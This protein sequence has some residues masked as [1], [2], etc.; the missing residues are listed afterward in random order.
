MDE[1]EALP[2][3]QNARRRL[4]ARNEA[5]DQPPSREAVCAPTSSGRAAVGHGRI[6]DGASAA[7]AAPDGALQAGPTISHTGPEA[8]GEGSKS[9]TRAPR[10]RER[11]EEEEDQQRPGSAP[12]DDGGG[13]GGGDGALPAYRS[14]AVGAFKFEYLDHTA[15]VQLHAWGRDLKEAFEN[16]GLAMFNYMSPLE[17][18]RPRETRSYRAEGHDLPS[19]LY[20]FLDELLFVFATELFLAASLTI[21]TFDRVNWVIEA[22]GVGEAFDR[23]VHEVGTE[24]KAITYS[25][26]A[27][28]E[29]RPDDAE[30]F[31]IVDI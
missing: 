24:I 2:Q 6:K 8:T 22:E 27:I 20:G 15:D 3:R 31:V 14:A 28:S 10:S 4:R 9:P 18:V 26:M 23:E 5:E 21:T 30:V 16:C 12:G 25:A 17:L 1:G 19:L 13:G 7:A 11:E 29:E